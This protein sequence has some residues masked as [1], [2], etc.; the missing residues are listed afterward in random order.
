MKKQ[1]VYTESEVDT[2]IKFINFLNKLS[3]ELDNEHELTHD[4]E[5]IIDKT[6]NLVIVIRDFFRAED[7]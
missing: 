7:D 6:I 1:L 2:L 4:R 5:E 3:D